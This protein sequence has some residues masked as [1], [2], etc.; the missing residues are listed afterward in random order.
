[1][2]GACNGKAQALETYVILD[3]C[4]QATF[5]KENLS[6]DLGIKERKTSITVKT[7]NGEVTKSS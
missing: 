1:M 6:T 3:T 7:M 2:C 4:S 5:A